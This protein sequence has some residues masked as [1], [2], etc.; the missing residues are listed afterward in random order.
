MF[1]HF[2]SSEAA[3]CENCGNLASVMHLSVRRSPIVLNLCTVCFRAL[4]VAM[5]QAC[6]KLETAPKPERSEPSMVAA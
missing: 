5:V 1:I 4:T 2:D 6:K 3:R